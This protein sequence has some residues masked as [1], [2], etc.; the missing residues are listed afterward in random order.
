[1]TLI[2]EACQVLEFIGSVLTMKEA[3]E[4]VDSRDAPSPEL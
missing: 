4:E 2:E 3:K 1:M